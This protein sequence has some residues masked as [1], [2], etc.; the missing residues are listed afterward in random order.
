MCCVSFFCFILLNWG[1]GRDL[2]EHWQTETVYTIYTLKVKFLR[3]AWFYLIYKVIQGIFARGALWLLVFS[4]DFEEIPKNA[5][6]SP[7]CKSLF[8]SSRAA[9]PSSK[10]AT[11]QEKEICEGETKR[12]HFTNSYRYKITAKNS[13]FTCFF[14]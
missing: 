2:G 5:E 11:R 1:A 9:S 4:R 6:N 13:I 7:T 12:E 14:S 10:K 3:Y 8:Y